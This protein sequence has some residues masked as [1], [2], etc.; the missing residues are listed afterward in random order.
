MSHTKGKWV[1]GY[2]QGVT[3]PSTPVSSPTV[4]EAVKYD[5]WVGAGEDYDNYPQPNHTIIS[6]GK[7]T[8]AIIPLCRGDGEANAQRIVTAVNS[9]DAMVD[10]LGDILEWDG[11]LPH[12]KARIQQVLDQIGG[13]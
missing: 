12:S 11:I 1:N 5:D 9:H 4:G 10:L 3:G 7:E 2:G 13:E 6:V 8:V